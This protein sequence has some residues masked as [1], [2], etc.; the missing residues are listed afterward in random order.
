MTE[1]DPTAWEGQAV[2]WV[3]GDPPRDRPTGTG[4]AEPRRKTITHMQEPTKNISMN[5]LW[6]SCARENKL[7]P[8]RSNG[9][10]TGSENWK[11]QNE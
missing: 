4:T 10:T 7:W 2:D 1:Q 6:R 5:I 9:W 8:K 3:P 11:L